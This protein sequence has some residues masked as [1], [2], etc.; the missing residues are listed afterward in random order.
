MADFYNRSLPLTVLA[1]QVCHEPLQLKY[2]FE[3]QTC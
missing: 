1:S 3:F 2:S